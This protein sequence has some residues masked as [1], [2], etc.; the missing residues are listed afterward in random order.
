MV[1]GEAVLISKHG[2]EL[3]ASP[4]PRPLLC[5]IHHLINFTLARVENVPV[6]LAVLDKGH[7]SKRTRRAGGQRVRVGPRP[8]ENSIR[9]GRN[10]ARSTNF[11]V[12]SFSVSPHASKIM[13]R[14]YRAEFSHSL[15]Q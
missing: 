4:G 7:Q 9:F 2:L 12:Y 13:V 10:A 14:I 8:C 3:R 6:V 11:C 5:T 15:G 1:T